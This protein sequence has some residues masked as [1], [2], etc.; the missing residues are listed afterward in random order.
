MISPELAANLVLILHAGFIAFVVLGLV[1][2]WIG[3]TL[4]WRWVRNP[5]FRIVHL[6]CIGYVVLEAWTG[7]TCPLTEWEDNLRLRAGQSAYEPA[8]FI[9]DWLHRCIFFTAPPWVFV[10]CYTLFGLAV[11]G[12]LILSPPRWRAHGDA[13]AA[14]V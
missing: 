3:I 14:R 5:W 1:I 10:M 7:M 4:R 12:T 9:A 13:P 11:L 2:I 8:G 6:L